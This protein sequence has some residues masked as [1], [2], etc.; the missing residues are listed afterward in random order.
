MVQY[1]ASIDD[2]FPLSFDI[3]INAITYYNKGAFI[4]MNEFVL[5]NRMNSDQLNDYALLVDSKLDNYQN[6]ALNCLDITCK[7][8]EHKKQLDLTFQYIKDSLLEST[9]CYEVTSHSK[10]KNVPG[11]NK[12]C[13]TLH[14]IAQKSF[15]EWKENGKIRS[16]NKYNAMKESRK[17]F[18]NA[19]NYCKTNEMNL[20]KE[21]LLLN[22]RDKNKNKFWNEIKK[23]KGAKTRLVPFVDKANDEKDISEIFKNKFQNIF[24]TNLVNLNQMILTLCSIIT[25]II[26]VYSEY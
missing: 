2:H 1:S 5:W 9:K 21:S 17:A 4:D 14:N 7:N 18:R 25:L 13:K 10:S 8:I 20:R 24:M 15:M 23:V 12:H 19:F 6:E 22:F 26:K 11:W 16:G 3:E